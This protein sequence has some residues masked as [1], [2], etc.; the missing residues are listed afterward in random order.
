MKEI[1]IRKN[2]AGQRPT[3]SSAKAVSPAAGIAAAEIYPPQA[4]QAHTARAPSATC[5][6]SRGTCCNYNNDEFFGKP[7]RSTTPG[8]KIATLR[9]DIAHYDENILLAD[10]KPGVLSH[11]AGERSLDTLISNIQAYLRQN[12]Q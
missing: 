7:P 3:A 10:K 1:Q 8:W 5:A 11:S 6:S 12:G 4:H 2:D 9:L